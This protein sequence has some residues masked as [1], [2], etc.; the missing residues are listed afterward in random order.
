MAKEQETLFDLAIKRE[1]KIETK[2]FRFKFLL[3]PCGRLGR[4]LY[5]VVVP[6]TVAVDQLNFNW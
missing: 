1:E 6:T 2:G 3:Q 5:T 4:Q